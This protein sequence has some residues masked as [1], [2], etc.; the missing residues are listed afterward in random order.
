MKICYLN[1]LFTGRR[2]ASLACAS[3]FPALGHGQEAAPR[4]CGTVP[5]PLEQSREIG[6]G[7]KRLRLAN[8]DKLRAKGKALIL[9]WAHVIHDS[10]DVGR[11]DKASIERQVEVLNECFGPHGFKFQLAEIDTT[12]NDEWFR[13]SYGSAAERAAKRHLSQSPQTYLNLYTVQPSDFLLGW[14]AW[15][16]ELEENP[17]MDGVVIDYRTL[18]GGERGPY[19]LGKTA[20]HECGH[21]LGL[22]HTFN[23]GCEGSG[24]EVDDTPAERE[25][26][27]GCPQESEP[28]RDTCPD[29]PGKDSIRNYMNYVDDRC[30][31]EFTKGQADRMWSMTARYRVALF[32]REEVASLNMADSEAP[33]AVTGSVGIAEAVNIADEFLRQK[34]LNWGEPKTI[35]IDGDRFHLEFPTSPDEERR[36]GQRALIID[37]RGSVE[38]LPR[39]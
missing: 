2:L 25:P 9:V 34:E 31:T 37:E 16:W 21:W 22:Y 4:T 3:L 10:N 7:L 15:P 11:V 38:L 23:G 18:P 20:V 8:H 26:S 19:D 13:M 39:R 1:P 27:T 36:V 5:P 6:E 35:K 33:V 32:P 30:M 29:H 14:A 28:G 12:K 24:D 17:K